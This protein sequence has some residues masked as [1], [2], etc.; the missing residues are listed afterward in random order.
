M[1]PRITTLPALAL[2]LTASVSA[3]TTVRQS[4][5]SGGEEGNHHSRHATLSA[6]GRWIAFDSEATTFAPSDTNAATDVFLH[7]RRNGTTSCLSLGLGGAP[8]DDH[9]T[10]P[11]LSADGRFVAFQS[12]AS[13]LVAGDTN[14]ASDVFVRD[15]QLGTTERV[16]VGTGGAQSTGGAVAA[17]ISADGRFVAFTSTASDLVPGDTNTFSDVFLRDRLLG[18]TERV[19]VGAGGL[20]A[21]DFSAGPSISG[22][23]RFVAFYSAASN[24]V[25]GDTNA[26]YDVFVRD[27]VTATTLRASVGPGGVEPLD[28]C[29][30]CALSADGRFVAF[31]SPATNLIASDTN[32]LEDVFVRD[33]AAGVTEIVD[34]DDAGLQSTGFA[35][36]PSISADGRFVT[37]LSSASGLVLGDTNGLSDIFVRDRLTST[38]VRAS[39]SSTNA[40]GDNGCDTSSITPDGR[41]VLFSTLASNLGPWDTNARWDVYLRDRSVAAPITF[42]PDDGYVQACPCGNSGGPGRGCANSAF[43]SGGRLTASGDAHVFTDTLVLDASN[44]TGAFCIF[45]QGDWAVPPVPIDD[46]VGCVGGNLFRL[47]TKAVVGNTSR[48]PEGGDTG[49][50]VR[51][52]LPPTEVRRFYQCFYRNAAASFCPPATSNRTNALIFDWAVL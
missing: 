47:G 11:S 7:D 2:T 41:Y 4:T 28:H 30:D 20:Q 39:V 15:V 5:G 17:S 9:S 8:G 21:N 16:S 3:Q 24:L 52:H 33:L 23:G 32:P 25:A 48:Y 1:H 42:C 35:R 44:L 14:G 31:R 13:D 6:D 22:D 46:G 18:T 40:Q 36:M 29:F 49:I 51:G 37:F 38:T 50:S 43:T 10:L 34:V 45:F 19:S 26:R 12:F 27:R